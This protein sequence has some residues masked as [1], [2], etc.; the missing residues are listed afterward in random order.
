M[1]MVGY[2]L[3]IVCIIV[4]M[5]QLRVGHPRRYFMVLM[6]LL[7]SAYN[8]EVIVANI[9]RGRI[10]GMMDNRLC[11]DIA[12]MML[13]LRNVVRF[14][15]VNFSHLRILNIDRCSGSTMVGFIGNLRFYLMN[16]MHLVNNWHL[17]MNNWHF[18]MN[19]LMMNNWRMIIMFNNDRLPVI[20]DFMTIYFLHRL[21]MRLNN[22]MVCWLNNCMVS[23]WVK[24]LV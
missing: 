9:V 10:G 1:I 15:F 6:V 24:S 21:S 18:V 11:L 20:G 17:L 4:L 14:I 7:V 2:R 13:I 5:V 12:L 3:D 22:C 23:F 8:R 16:F 19:N